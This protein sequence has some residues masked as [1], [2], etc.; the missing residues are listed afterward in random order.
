[1]RVKSIVLA[2][3]AFMLFPLLSACSE[4]GK[5]Q[6]GEEENKPPEISTEPATLKFAISMG[7][8]GENE[9]QTYFEGP[10]KKRFPHISFEIYDMSKPEFSL[11]KLVGSGI[12]PDLVMTASPIIYRFTGMGME[13]NIEPLIKKFN[14]DLSKYNPNAVESVKTSSQIPYLTG[15]PWTLHFSAL[16]YNKDIFDKF[17]VPYPKDGMTWEDAR[18]LARKVTRTEGNV[19]YRG[20]EPDKSTRVAS[21]LSYGF[22]DPKTEKAI[23][24]TDGWKRVFELL[25]SIYDIPGNGGPKLAN[26][27]YDQFVKNRTLA[28]L[29]SVNYLPNLNSVPDLNWDMAQYPSFPEL[30]GVGIQVD[31]WILHITAQSKYKDQ[32]FQVIA[33][34]LSDEVQ[35]EV[36]RNARFPVLMGKNVQEVFGAN[37]PNLKGK[38]LEVAFK[39]QPAKAL[40]VSIYDSYAEPYMANLIN[41]VVKGDK[42]I[43]TI[44]REAEEAINKNIEANKVK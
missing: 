33:T 27:G 28:M 43:N 2:I 15:L 12:I 37:M 30:P 40:P 18:E 42:D 14:L 3:I 1:M 19:Q 29:T 11:D 21:V 32:A 22:V 44:L 41:A 7:W 13:Y 16:Y 23:V 39:S 24:N 31:E 8:L 20:L 36:A 34:V 35:M 38:R 26:A 10:V 25:K 4:G 6:A 9:F 17:G 5:K